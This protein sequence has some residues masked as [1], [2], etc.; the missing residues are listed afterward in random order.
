MSKKISSFLFYQVWH[1]PHAGDSEK[2]YEDSY[3]PEG[4]FSEFLSRR[5]F[6]FAVADGVSGAYF[7]GRWAKLLTN[8]FVRDGSQ[9]IENNDYLQQLASD[10]EREEEKRLTESKY[11]EK[12]QE[13][14]FNKIHD[15]GGAATFNGLQIIAKS[16]EWSSIAVGDACFFQIRDHKIISQNPSLNAEEFNDWPDQISTL[17]NVDFHPHI[18]RSYGTYLIGDCFF[19]A[20]DSLACWL[21]SSFPEFS[22][23]D[24]IKRLL[25]INSS[26]DFLEFITKER[27]SG[28][29]KDD[30]VTL[31]IIKLSPRRLFSPSFNQTYKPRYYRNNKY[32]ITRIPTNLNI[33][34]GHNDMGNDKL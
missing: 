26:N 22:F 7:S 3:F 16:A 8:T 11:D 30:D 34:A 29:L 15:T 13:Y 27:D 10:W 28:R 32:H 6:R 23:E 17:P 5:L 33:S 21:V 1:L 14:L 9:F 31:S 4:L 18:T 19:L 12:I 2:M 20:T 24:K 25:S